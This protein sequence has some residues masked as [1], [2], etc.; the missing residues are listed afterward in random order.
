M[1]ERGK[2]KFY[3]F[4]PGVVNA[5]ANDFTFLNRSESAQGQLL[6]TIV[7]N[8][9]R[10]AAEYLEFDV[11]LSYWRGPSNKEIDFIVKHHE[12]SIGIEVKTSSKWE[13]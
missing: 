6:E 7:L 11:Q 12:T 5:I 4:D 10:A 1:R 2:P 13:A 8:E 3:F 9:L